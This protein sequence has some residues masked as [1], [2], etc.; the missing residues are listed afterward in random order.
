MMAATRSRPECSASD[1]T[2]KL[3]VR[4]TRKVLSETKTRAETTLSS[5]A[6]FFS[7][8]S[9]TTRVGITIRLDYRSLVAL[10][11]FGAP[12]ARE[13]FNSGSPSRQ[14]TQGRGIYAVAQAGGLRPIGEYVT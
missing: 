7:F 1:N 8:T 11:A 9:S 10:A 5:A 4:M 13:V 6:R 12:L 3:P 2:P 14:E